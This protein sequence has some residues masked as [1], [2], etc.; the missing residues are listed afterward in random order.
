MVAILN[1]DGL[2]LQNSETLETIAERVVKSNNA[3][4]YSLNVRRL[5][6]LYLS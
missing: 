3:D 5:V 4:Q 6:V 2:L 1:F